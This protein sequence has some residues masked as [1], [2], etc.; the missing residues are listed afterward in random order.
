MIAVFAETERNGQRE[1]E[2]EECVKNESFVAILVAA[3]ILVWYL[4]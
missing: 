2:S 1:N 4:F 3:F